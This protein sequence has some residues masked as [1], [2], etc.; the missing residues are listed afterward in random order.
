M[1]ALLKD[2]PYKSVDELKRNAVFYSRLDHQFCFQ[3]HSLISHE[4]SSKIP[5][6]RIKRIP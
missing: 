3:L 6:P 5:E 2:N 1:T 4:E